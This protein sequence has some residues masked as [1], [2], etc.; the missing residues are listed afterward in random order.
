MLDLT[1][2][3]A[4]ILAK[5]DAIDARVLVA[6]AE[7]IRPPLLTASV[8]EQEQLRNLEAQRRHLMHL[9]VMEQNRG[10]R[11]S[12]PSVERL[13]RRLI[14]QIQKQIEQLDLLIEQPIH[15]SAELELKAQK[16]T[17]ISGAGR[18]TGA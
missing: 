13:N 14:N 6:F 12:Q 3:A 7:A 10:A 1:A 18:R 2:R 16:L 11:L 8:L 15:A 4:G 17:A 5:T 9:L